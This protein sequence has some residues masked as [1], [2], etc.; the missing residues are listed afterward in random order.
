MILTNNEVHGLYNGLC[1]L[2]DSSSVE[3]P[4][5]IAY[6]LIQDIKILEA[7]YMAI[8]EVRSREVKKYGVPQDDGFVISNDNLKIVNEHLTELGECEND[9]PLKKLPLSSLVG[10]YFTLQDMNLLYPLIDGEA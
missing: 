3:L 9:L 4:I 7:S 6:T 8:E 1:K 5:S 10:Q 2:R